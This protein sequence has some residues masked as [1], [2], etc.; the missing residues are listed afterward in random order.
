M[1]PLQT[2]VQNAVNTM[3]GTFMSPPSFLYIEK[4]YTKK[5]FQENLEVLMYIGY[6]REE[7]G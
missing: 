2:A 7:L 4:C 5:M 3:K 6:L 1:E